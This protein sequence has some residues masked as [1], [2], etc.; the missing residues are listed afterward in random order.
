MAVF[1]IRFKY[2]QISFRLQ[3][4]QEPGNAA[5]AISAY[6]SRCS[7]CWSSTLRSGHDTGETMVKPNG[8]FSSRSLLDVLLEIVREMNHDESLLCLVAFFWPIN[9][10]IF[11]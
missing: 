7:F 8:F 10:C 4:I 2:F 6:I 3:N 11:S 5:S 9:L 1:K